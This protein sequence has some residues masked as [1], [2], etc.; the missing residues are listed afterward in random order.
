[1]PD[2]P[3]SGLRLQLRL[4]TSSTPPVDSPPADAASW[5]AGTNERA[6]VG[7]CYACW[8]KSTP[9]VAAHVAAS[10]GRFRDALQRRFGAR[11]QRVVLF[12]SQAR[13]NAHEDSDVDVLV[14]VD[15]L[16]VDE[17]RE[18]VDLAHDADAVDRNNWAGLAPLAK[19]TEQ[20][21]ALRARE[22]LIVADIEAEGVAL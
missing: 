6:L 10:L 8:V 14:V 11:L 15:D 1:M 13:G 3:G 9:G 4:S 2:Q 12:G 16:S 21:E 19:S 5:E 17:Q 20:L 7:W 18:I 22:L